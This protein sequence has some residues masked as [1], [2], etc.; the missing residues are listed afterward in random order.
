[1]QAFAQDEGYWPRSYFAGIGMGVVATR[2]DIGDKNIKYD[3]DDG[4]SETVH[5]P[6]MDL[7][8]IPDFFIGVNIREFSVSVNFNYWK[9]TEVL[10]G[11]PD[12]SN[13]QPTRIYR[14]GVEFVYNLYWPEFFQPQIGLGYA[15]TSIR[16]NENVFSSDTEKEL[17]SS[18]LMGS[19]LALILGIRYFL[20][21]HLIIQPDLKFYEAW[22]GHLNTKEMGTFDLKHKKWQ[23]FAIMEVDLV[24]QF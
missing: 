7:L 4:T 2:G 12:D 18:E 17:T 22:F 14:L 3:L 10:G 20:T 16:T 19:S 8:A 9:Y 6:A 5:L 11:F 15:F 21:D 13:E 24:W 1:M 23:T